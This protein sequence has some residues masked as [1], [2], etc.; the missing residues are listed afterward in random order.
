MRRN[1][2]LQR[3]RAGAGRPNYSAPALEKGLDVLEL[4]AGASEGLTHTVIAQRLGRSVQEVYR[5]VRALER[6]G[7]I[8]RRAPDGSFWL[9][10]KLYQLATAF[11]PVRLL[12]VRA[13]PLMQRLAREVQQAVL[14]S[15][16][17]GASIWPI[18]YVDSPA[19]VGFRV[20]LGTPSPAARTAS[21]R[22]LLAFQDPAARPSSCR[23]LAESLDPASFRRVTARIEAVRARGFEL[24]ADETIRGVTDVSF[25]V[26]DGNGVALAALTMP[27]L[28]TVSNP[29]SLDKA[30]RLLF[31]AAAE[32]SEA[33]GGRL[34]RPAFPLTSMARG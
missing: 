6:R 34:V 5:M 12:T 7:Y 22:V 1:G 13:T 29:V 23:M 3:G 2:G 15:V 32:L 20:R 21:G 10:M 11:P 28:E 19:H 27:F 31:A 8:V 16:L 9:S 26:L 25:P 4:L 17:E 24:V 18:V 30:G 33:A 14:L